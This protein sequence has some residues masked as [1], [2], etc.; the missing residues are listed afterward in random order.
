[1]L[2]VTY[3]DDMPM[4]DELER[5][6]RSLLEDGTLSSSDAERVARVLREVS[7]GLRRPALGEDVSD[8]GFD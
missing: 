5:L 8:E 3:D 2:T 1:M 6:A 7:A 4:P